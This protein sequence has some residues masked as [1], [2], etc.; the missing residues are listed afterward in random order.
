MGIYYLETGSGPR[1]SK[2]IYDR[3]YSAISKAKVS[4]FN[5]DKVFENA[6]WFHITGIT[7]ALSA[8]A[9]ELSLSYRLRPSAS[10]VRISP[11]EGV[12]TFGIRRT[13]IRNT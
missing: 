4:E 12:V 3:A 13:G 11:L 5:W 10:W 6:H 9:A 2:V 8:T 7:P 1:P